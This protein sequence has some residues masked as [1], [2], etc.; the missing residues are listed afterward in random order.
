EVGR[1]IRIAIGGR[2]GGVTGTWRVILTGQVWT[3]ALRRAQQARVVS[4][5]ADELHA[6]RH[7]V[8][9]GHQW[10][11]NRW[12]TKVCPQ[13]AEHRVAGRGSLRGDTG[14]SWSNDGIALLL[15]QLLERVAQGKSARNCT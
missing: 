2:M 15:K 1:Q 13:C 12:K 11:S 4:W 9:A 6:E 14:R 8:F 10:Q 7:S 3:P 5:C